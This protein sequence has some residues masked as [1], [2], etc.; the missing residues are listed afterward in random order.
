MPVL[1]PDEAVQ[2]AR[3]V[4]SKAERA[5]ESAP[6]DSVPAGRANALEAWVRYRFLGPLDLDAKAGPS[7][8]G[9]AS[10]LGVA[11]IGAGLASST[12][13]G[14]GDGVWADAT[15]GALGVTVGVLTAINQIWRPGTR[16]VARYQSAFGLRREGWDYVHDRGRYENLG[17]MAQLDLLI[18]EIGR[19]NLVVEAVDR[20]A[21]SGDRPDDQR[22]ASAT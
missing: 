18:D 1:G 7:Y 6:E 19:T 3:L 15:I 4:Q 13:A 2:L 12:I 8:G 17:P 21:L 11:T 5:L 9:A 10:L 16:S 14:V 20:A 22:T